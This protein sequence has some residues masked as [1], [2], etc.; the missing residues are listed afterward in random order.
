MFFL[1]YKYMAE[2]EVNNNMAVLHSRPPT[3]VLLRHLLD[4]LALV[5]SLLVDHRGEVE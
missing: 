1:S 4:D 2:R 3:S 5:I